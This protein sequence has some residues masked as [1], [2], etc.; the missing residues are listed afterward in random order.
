APILSTKE[1]EYSSSMGYEHPNTTPETK[2]DEIIK[3]SV[4]ELV[5]ISSECEVTSEDESKCDMPIQD[6]ASL[7]F[8]TFSNHLFKDNDDLTSNDDESLFEEDIPIEESKVYSNPLSKSDAPLSNNTFS[9]LEMELSTCNS[10]T[11]S[12]SPS[13]SSS[14]STP[15]GN[16]SFVLVTISISSL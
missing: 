2:S 4:E 3:S 16:N 13:E 9:E 11:A 1:P 14:F 7:V 8:T 6:Q 5:S 10:S 15:G 12:I